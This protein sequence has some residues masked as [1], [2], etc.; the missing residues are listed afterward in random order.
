LKSGGR[1]FYRLNEALGQGIFNR[2]AAAG[3]LYNLMGN[4]EAKPRTINRFSSGGVNAEERLEYL[5]KQFRRDARALILNGD[6]RFGGRA[7][8]GDACPLSVRSGIDNQ[9]PE[10]AREAGSI[11]K[12][13]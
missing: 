10:C 4:R 13:N 5:P 2:D 11:R 12:N 7:L 3:A 8:D 9:I 1:N 6:N